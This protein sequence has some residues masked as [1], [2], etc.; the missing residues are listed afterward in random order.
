M[1]SEKTKAW[2]HFASQLRKELTVN[3]PI[4]E[5]QR[6]LLEKL[7]RLEAQRR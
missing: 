5:A 6:R 7:R 3:T 4:P 1:S 2:E